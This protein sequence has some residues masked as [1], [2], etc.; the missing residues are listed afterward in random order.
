MSSRNY[1]KEYKLPNG[2]SVAV[3]IGKDGFTIWARKKKG[4][5]VGEQWIIDASIIKLSGNLTLNIRKV[6]DADKT[7]LVASMF[8]DIQGNQPTYHV[9]IPRK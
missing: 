3:D 6:T 1:V 7:G 4:A 9:R 5:D 8:S 2:G